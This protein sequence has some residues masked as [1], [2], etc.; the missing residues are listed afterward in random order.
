MTTTDS[1]RGYT[2]AEACAYVGGISRPKIYEL[3]ADGQLRSYM[4]GVRRY[5]LREELD[6]FL[7]RQVEESGDGNG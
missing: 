4:I 6:S 1:K 3:M 7:E 5:F 2:L